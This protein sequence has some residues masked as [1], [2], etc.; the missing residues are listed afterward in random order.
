MADLE[1]AA[2]SSAR[3]P[4]E[5]IEIKRR[6]GTLRFQTDSPE[7]AHITVKPEVCAQCPHS[8]CTFVCPAQC[9]ERIEGKLVFRYEDCVECGACDI[10]CD[11]G[12]VT[13]NFPRGTFGVRYAY[14]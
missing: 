3:R 5:A 10:A 11:Q 12:S 6:L 8:L 7:H 4:V 1:G 9:Y 2:P 13:W 14:G